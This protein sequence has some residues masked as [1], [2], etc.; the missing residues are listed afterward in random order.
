[1]KRLLQM[2][3]AAA[4]MLAA[5]MSSADD[6]QFIIS[7]DPVA[8]AS[9]GSKAVASPGTS[10]VT[11]TLTAPTGAVSLEARYRTWYESDGTA[12]RSDKANGLILFIK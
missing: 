10:L 1:M 9:V 6:Y 7:G 4:A 3:G 2:I 12:L 5:Q 11:G 8:A